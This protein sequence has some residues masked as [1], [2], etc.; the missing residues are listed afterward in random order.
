MRKLDS[1]SVVKMKRAD[2]SGEAFMGL[3]EVQE[4]LL[5][6]PGSDDPVKLRANLVRQAEVILNDLTEEDYKEF[7]FRLKGY[8]A[9]RPSNERKIYQPSKE[10]ILLNSLLSS[11]A[12]ETDFD[13]VLWKLRTEYERVVSDPRCTGCATRKALADVRRS[14][15]EFW[16]NQEVV[17]D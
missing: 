17:S 5:M 1:T 15:R 14:L 6:I 2:L 12:V 13:P 10:D 7:R 11:S 8:V 4:G 3:R 16:Q 9:G